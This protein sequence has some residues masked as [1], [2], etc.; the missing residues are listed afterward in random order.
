MAFAASSLLV[1]T[2]AFAHHM[3][4]DE[5][6]DFIT[7][8]LVAVDSPHLLSSDEDPSLLDTMGVVEGM[9]DVDYIVI[10]E[11]LDAD[12]VITA[13]E[14]ILLQLATENELC[15][16]KYVIDYVAADGTFTLTVYADFCDQ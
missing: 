7:D 5:M 8:Q 2:V 4:P 15:D 3:A 9:D 10:A 16:V 12:E 6:Q 11:G 13:L 1:L 14:A